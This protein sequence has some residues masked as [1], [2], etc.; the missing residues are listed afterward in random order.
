[1]LILCEP[2][3]PGQYRRTV[4]QQM[5]AVPGSA[6]LVRQPRLRLPQH[7]HSFASG[8]LR[9]GGRRSSWSLSAPWGRARAGAHVASLRW[10]GRNAARS[11]PGRGGLSEAVA[12][13]AVDEAGAALVVLAQ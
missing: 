6:Q 2:L 7:P 9:T 1:M 10:G 13:E 5:E 12:V 8:A 4:R 3:P 11:V